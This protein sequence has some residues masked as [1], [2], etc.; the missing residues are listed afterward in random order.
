M[1]SMISRKTALFLLIGGLAA[2]L[3]AVGVLFATKA[4]LPVIAIT[5]IANHPA[6]D[7]VRMGIISR[8]KDRG[9]VDG[10]DVEIVFRN[11]NGDPSLA[12]PIAQDFVRRQAAV[13]VPISTP[14]TLA[15]VK[16]TSTIPIVFSGVTDPV[17]LGIVSKQAG[18]GNVT[19]VSDQW[20][21]EAQLK[22]FQTFFPNV[23][24]I[25]M[26]F[27]RGDDISVIGVKAVQQAAPKLGLELQLQ[28][29]SSSADVY[30]SAVALF[31][32]V[33]AVYVG[34]DH[35]LLENIDTLVKVAGE[36]GKPLFGGETGSVRKG[37][38]LALSIDMSQF[39]ETTGDLVVEV[40]RGKP[41]GDIPFK[42]ITSGMLY[43]NARA[44][45]RFNLDVANLK[46][47]GATILD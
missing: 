13:I 1:A 40:L 19:G 28:A 20:P 22:A 11:A 30:P 4:S 26:L 8:L 25:G 6:L 46:S 33:D 3:I 15:T 10:R 27:T 37:A 12:L 21:F 38:V 24:R 42:V 34:I 45:Q 36:A 47:R 5:Q 35:L 18:R 17:G 23:K 14:S 9:Y 16:A 39:G 31:R 44:A 7:E 43:V 41:P 2:A 29:V 32:N